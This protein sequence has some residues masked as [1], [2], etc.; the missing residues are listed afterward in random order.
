MDDLDA[1]LAARAQQ[2]QPDPLD[3]MLQARAQGQTLS[4]PAAPAQ[5][6]AAPVAW[7]QQVAKGVSDANDA[8][9]QML[10]HSLPSGVVNAVNSAT[11]AVNDAPIIGPITKALNMTP[12]TSQQV[13][14]TIA[15]NEQRYQAGRA[16]A[17]SKGID[18]A[19]LLGSTAVTTP[20]AAAMPGAAGVGGGALAG[21]LYGGISAPVTEGDYASGKL[22][23]MGTGAVAGGATSAAVGALARALSPN[24]SPEVRTLMD[25]GVTPTPGQ[26]MGGGAKR[27]EDAATSI[28]VLGDAI[29]NAQRRSFQDLNDAAIN[30]ALAPIGGALPAGTTGRAAID[31]T[32]TQ[33]GNA[34][35]HV[36]NN[37]GAIH[38]DQQFGQEMTQLAALTRN[39]PQQTADQFDRIIQNE[40]MGRIDANGVMTPQNMKAAESNL[41]QIVRGYMRSPDYDTRQMATAVEQAQA[42]L[43]QMVQRVAPP[44]ASA[45]LQR[46]NEGWANFMRPQ[47]AAS[48]LGSDAGVFTPEQLQ[49]AVKALDPSRNKGAFARG[50]A[51]MQ[52]LSEAGKTVMGNKVPDSG[53]PLRHAVQAGLAL[54]A[55]HTVAPGI[56]GSAVAPL[57]AVG[58]AA[59]L[60][61]SATGQRL[62]AA[63]LTQRP[64][65]AQITA[66]QLRA[67]A[68]YLGAVT[69]P[70]LTK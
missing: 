33:L 22:K 10:V 49:S 66:D 8:G 65:G 53:T 57:A 5:P 41:G 28:P 14:Q 70:G 23:Q 56:V 31:Y 1:M 9:A 36:L 51:L 64:Q 69:V 34:Y 13:D 60:P 19:R 15:G 61:Y 47:R 24:V 29:K 52:D 50:D 32:Q 4:A 68:P 17:G 37:M 21:A 46:I 38:P 55:G 27:V 30:R 54:A 62:A 63:L 6:S 26:I 42:T 11:Q 59:M 12:A 3:A 25:A 44:Q 67:L 18:W 58:G 39:L 43:R 2:A 48:M 20:L 35:E 7:W 16:A 45:Q 40:V